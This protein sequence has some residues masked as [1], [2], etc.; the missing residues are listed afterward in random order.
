M[1]KKV[2]VVPTN[3]SELLSPCAIAYWFAGDGTFHKGKSV[4]QVATNSFTPEEVDLLRA[5]LLERYDIHSSRVLGGT[6]GRDQYIIRIPRRELTK[7]Q[8][9]IK[10]ICHL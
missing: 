5:V 2:K 3:I 4:I 6:K 8:D 7:V 10:V 1:V 9:L